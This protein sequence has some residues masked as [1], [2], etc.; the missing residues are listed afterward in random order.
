MMRLKHLELALSRLKRPRVYK[1]EFEQYTL[2]AKSAAR[3]LYYAEF[4]HGD[5]FGKRVA[6]M[7]CG[8]GLLAIGACLLGAKEVVGVD[9]DRDCIEVARENCAIAGCSV[10]LVVGDIEALTKGFDVVVMNPPFGTWHRGLDVRFLQKAVEVA[11]VVYS[12]HKQSPRSREFLS[13][14]VEQMGARV[15]KVYP[16]DVVLPH[17]YEF[18]EKAKYVVRA[19]LYR[20]CRS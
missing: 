20:I 10:E 19:D 11:D 7:G 5:I 8:S 18:H 4:V 15:D 13:K 6:D 3:I 16:V 14:K 12:L 9:I 1:L 2:D 17:V